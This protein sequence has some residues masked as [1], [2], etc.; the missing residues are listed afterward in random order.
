[1]EY[2]KSVNLATARPAAAAWLPDPPLLP[3]L[4]S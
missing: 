2:V 1:M 3:Q 4:G